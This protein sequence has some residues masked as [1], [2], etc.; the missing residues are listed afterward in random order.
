MSYYVNVLPDIPLKDVDSSFTYIVP[1]QLRGQA[2]FGK[3]VLIPFGKRLIEGFIVDCPQIVESIELN[4]VL[5]IL[6][7]EPVL[8]RNLYALAQWVAEYYLCSLS[9]VIHSMIPRIIDRKKPSFVIPL[10]N[11]QET[12]ILER[13]YPTRYIEFLTKIISD[14]EMS[15]K[16]AQKYVDKDDLNFLKQQNLIYIGGNYFD[17]RRSKNKYVYIVKAFSEDTNMPELEKKAPR[18]AEAMRMLLERGEISQEDLDKLFSPRCTRALMNKGYIDIQRHKKAISP[19]VPN[20]TPE[21]EFAVSQINNAVLER[22]TREFLLFGVTGS[23]KTEVYLRA[24]QNT[25][26]LKKQVIILVPE[27]ALT[28]HLVDIFSSRINNIAVLHSG[29]PDSERYDEWKRIKSREVDLI[30][31]TRS[32]IFAPVTDLGLIIIDEEQENTYKQEEIPRYHAR[33]VARKRAEL[34][35]AVL[36]LGS[37]TPSIETFN[38]AVNQKIT[39][40]NMTHRVKGASMPGIYVQDMRVPFKKGDRRILS[41]MLIKKIEETLSR[42]EQ[43]ILFINRRGYSPITICRECG[44][45][46]LC[47]YCAVGMTYHNNLDLNVCHYCNYKTKIHTTCVFCGSKHLQQIGQGTQKVEEETRHCFPEA[48]VERLDL[49]V[50]RKKGLQK[51]ILESMKRKDVDILIG[52]QMVAKGLD[53]PRVSLVGIIDIDSMFNIPD[54]RAGERCFQ[55]VVQAAGRAGRGNV[56]G[57]VVIQTYNPDNVVL[58]KIVANDYQSFFAEE[59]QIRKLLDYPPFCNI[60]RIVIVSSELDKVE[61]AASMVKDEVFDIIDAKEDSIDLIGPAPCPIYKL[62]NKYRYHLLIKGNNMLLLNSIGRYIINR[63]NIRGIKL[64]VDI[65]P[66]VFM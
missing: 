8:D 45:V 49:D 28:R 12:S 10:I 53:F 37:A 20:L 3:R 16:E 14:G 63:I 26:A 59:I 35:G 41:P 1:P 47:P 7:P 34:E 65:N 46:V 50:S 48:R 33:E 61:K 62:R 24:A 29:M 52:T 22:S 5:K 31:G 39:M 30:L 64:E 11:Q 57:E 4:K 21:Q 51:A 43:I 42:G 2:E 23:G 60:L 15:I 55:L 44:K 18:Q 19:S 25:M 9:I 36:V 17:H 56:P 13:K 32:A 6:D 40:L 27:I 38:A 66:L 58:N 54:F